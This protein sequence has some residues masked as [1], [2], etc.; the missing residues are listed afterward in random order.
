MGPIRT[1]P[2]GTAIS[3]VPPEGRSTFDLHSTAA[4]TA[5]T[6]ATTVELG[7]HS[8]PSHTIAQTPT[9]LAPQCYSAREPKLLILLTRQP[10]KGARGNGE[11][12]LPQPV[13]SQHKRPSPHK[14]D[15][16]PED[17]RTS[18]IGNAHS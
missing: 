10:L 16:A 11:V 18:A 1:L 17:E 12:T 4:T 8:R 5:E 2:D 3:G 13:L 15:T 14:S 7:A 9:G 6:S